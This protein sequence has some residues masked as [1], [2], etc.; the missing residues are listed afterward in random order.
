MKINEITEAPV[1]AFVQAAQGIGSR[2]LNRIGAKDTAASL[3]G[4]ADLSATANNLNRE[5]IRYLGTQGK[6]LDQATGRDLKV[7]LNDKNVDTS[8]IPN[9]V[10]GQ[11]R[12]NAVMLQKSIQAMAGKGAKK[13]APSAPAAAKTPVSSQYSQA[14][15]A[16]LKLSAKEKDRLIA[17]L[18]KSITRKPTKQPTVVDKNFDKSQRLS[19]YGKV[20]R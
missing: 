2:V 6:S 15:D 12:I 19:Q 16:A 1:N 10:L 7:F 3:A 14:K 20:G 5:F 17:V 11:K 8:G 13:T 18:G 4:R 9:G